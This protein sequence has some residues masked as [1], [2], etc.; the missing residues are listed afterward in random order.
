MVCCYDPGKYTSI[1]FTTEQNQTRQNSYFLF[2]HNTM[3]IRTCNWA[4]MATVGSSSGVCVCVCEGC[5]VEWTELHNGNFT[6]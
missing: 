5:S 2:S 4:A 3:V 6:T 1:I